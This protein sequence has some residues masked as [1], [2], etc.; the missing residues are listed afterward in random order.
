MHAEG[1]QPEHTNTNHELNK[2]NKD[3]NSTQTLT[4][5]LT[6]I[7]QQR[8]FQPFRVQHTPDDAVLVSFMRATTM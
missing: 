1:E 6:V 3:A 4:L 8:P 7:L 5:P 2:T